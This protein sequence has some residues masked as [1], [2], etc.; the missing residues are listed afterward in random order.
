VLQAIGAFLAIFCA[1]KLA[2]DV[3]K[4]AAEAERKLAEEREKVLGGFLKNPISV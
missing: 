4:R 1:I 3:E 2:R